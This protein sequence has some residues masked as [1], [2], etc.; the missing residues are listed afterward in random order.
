MPYPARVLSTGGAG[1]D[2]TMNSTSNTP[3]AKIGGVSHIVPNLR[4]GGA[5][6]LVSPNRMLK[7]L[8]TFLFYSKIGL[9]RTISPLG[10]CGAAPPDGGPCRRTVDDVQ[11]EPPACLRRRQR[12]QSFGAD[13]AGLVSAQVSFDFGLKVTR[14]QRSSL[15]FF[16]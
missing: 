15:D 10:H 3:A 2:H 1:S 7:H 6:P 11:W 5:R 9:R 4:A 13:T 16:R 14:S 12:V 8:T